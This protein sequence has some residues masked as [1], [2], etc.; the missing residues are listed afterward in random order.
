MLASVLGNRLS[1]GALLALLLSSTW[2]VHNCFAQVAAPA[3]APPQPRPPRQVE[4]LRA[5]QLRGAP[6]VDLVGNPL[7]IVDDLLIEVE[8][9]RVAALLV[10]SKSEDAGDDVGTAVEAA[11][12]KVVPAALANYHAATDSRPATVQITIPGA[13]TLW[14]DAPK[15]PPVDAA[16]APLPGRT[17]TTSPSTIASA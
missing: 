9:S 10:R 12:I 5:T 2:F 3:S 13:S 16:G 17:N 1:T 7:G 8:S 15:W 6:V 14:R 4:L 11:P